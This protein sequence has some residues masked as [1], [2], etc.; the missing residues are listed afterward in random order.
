MLKIFSS[1]LSRGSKTVFTPG[2]VPISFPAQNV[3][4]ISLSSSRNE[5][6]KPVGP[7]RWPRQ[8]K[9]V[10]PPQEIGEERR[11]A[12]VCHMNLNFKYSPDKLWYVAC[13]VRGMTIDEALR[14]LDYVKKKGAW[15][16]KKTLLEAQELAVKEHNVEFKSNLWVSESFVGKGLVVHGIRRHA[17]MRAGHI[18]YRYA[19]Y[20][21]RLEEGPPLENI[22]PHKLPR[23][24]PTLLQQWI[25]ERRNERIYNSV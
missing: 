1:I 12:F 3:R 8:N 10:F 9:K 15:I 22:Y 20:F 18:T 21:V 19:H 24:G 14:Q 25:E 13:M 6:E 11:P 5:W 17:R 23:D 16:V 7:R 4:T 2:I